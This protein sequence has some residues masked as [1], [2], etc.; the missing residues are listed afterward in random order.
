[1][2]S[3]AKLP[4]K[5]HEVRQ[6]ERPLQRVTAKACRVDVVVREARVTTIK[7]GVERL[8]VLVREAERLTSKG[9]EEVQGREVVAPRAAM[10]LAYEPVKASEETTRRA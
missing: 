4:Q 3:S 8:V 2:A 6:A 1:M 5:H 7:R 10:R 9:G